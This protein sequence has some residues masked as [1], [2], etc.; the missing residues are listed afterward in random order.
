MVEK[1][2]T[3]SAVLL[4]TAPSLNALYPSCFAKIWNYAIQ[5]TEW[6]CATIE[7][8][9]T[10]DENPAVLSTT[11][12]GGTTSTTNL[13][14][15]ISQTTTVTASSPASPGGGNG[16]SNGINGN[17]NTQND[18]NTYIYNNGHGGTSGS[19]TDMIAGGLKLMLKLHAFLALFFLGA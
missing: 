14:P 6:D 4:L 15:G 11:T 3:S 13:I 19:I 10:F 1:H 2:L 12:F 18:G 17:S 8:Y 16:N 5:Y 7:G 9:V